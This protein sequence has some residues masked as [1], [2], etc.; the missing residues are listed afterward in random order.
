MNKVPSASAAQILE[1]TKLFINDLSSESIKEMYAVF[2]EKKCKK[3]LKEMDDDANIQGKTNSAD[4]TFVV[5]KPFYESFIEDNKIKTSTKGIKNLGISIQDIPDLIDK[6]GETIP[7]EI[8][9]W[10]LT[11]HGTEFDK[12]DYFLIN[13][14]EKPG[15]CPEA[16][17]IVSRTDPDV[18][19]KFLDTFIKYIDFSIFSGQCKKRMFLSF[20]ICRYA[21]EKTMESLTKEASNW[22][23]SSAG[24][25]APP[26]LSFRNAN[27]YSN[28]RSAM[29]FAERY[30]DLDKYAELRDMD[31]DTLR[32]MYLSDIGLD[33][34]GGKEYDLGNQIVIARLQKDLTFL[35]ELPTG[36]TAKSLPKKGADTKKYE[37]A[38][39]DFGEMKKAA[40]KILKSRVNVLFGDFLSGKVRKAQEW[41]D[42]YLNNPLL[43][44]IARIVVWSQ[45]N[46]TFV[47]TD[48]GAIDC[49]GQEYTITDEEIKIAHPMEMDK[50][51][52]TA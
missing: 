24:N 22:G 26:L 3:Q 23:T 19:Q 12:Y 28:T 6:D 52:V 9:A 13:G 21:D 20:P 32:D 30:D 5:K 27:L 15:I 17:K 2:T 16:Q 40:K 7:K 47:L 8:T 36:K 49:K 18:F 42:A 39:K 51:D 43:R 34:Q 11:V 41:K 14:Y 1:Y 44:N 4:G 37:A 48:S 33:A 38:K 31:E 45:G 25:D 29:L 35:F 46:S 50:A 10:L